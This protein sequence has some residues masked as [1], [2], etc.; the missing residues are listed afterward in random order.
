MRSKRLLGRAREKITLARAQY[1]QFRLY[2]LGSYAVN[3]M[4]SQKGYQLQM[5]VAYGPK[6]RQCLDVFLTDNARAGQ[7]LLVF[8]H[9]GAWSHGDK[10]DYRFVGQA[11]AKAGFDVAVIN[12]QLAPEHI[13]PTSIDDLVLALN[14]LHE[15]QSEHQICTDHVVLMGHS[16]GAFNVMSALYHPTPSS[17]LCRAQIRAVIGLAGPYHFD[18]KG[19]PLCADAFDQA[20]SY[21]QVMPYYFV[22]ANQIRH[23]LYV[24]ANDTIVH[25][26]NALDF[27]QALKARGNHSELIVVPRTGHITI[28]GSVAS[29]F[30]RYFSTKKYILAALDE[31]FPT[32]A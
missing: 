22:E 29:L 5:D 25:P 8:V 32:Q 13:F 27:D 18:Y 4:M 19:D 10:Q 16:A 21:T 23:Y 3:H 26:K 6:P 24:A 15:H 28:M 30:S 9:G 2:D 31:V 11:F 17:L 12:Y 20:L 7:P 1:Q 14:Y